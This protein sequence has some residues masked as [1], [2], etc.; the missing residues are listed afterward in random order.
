MES[1]GMA[2]F[3]AVAFITWGLWVNWEHGVTARWQVACTQGLVSFA[4]TFASAEIIRFITLQLRGSR[5]RIILWGGAI[6]YLLIYSAIAIVH[7][8]A[9]TPEIFATLLPGL[10]IGIP[11]CFSYAYRVTRS[12]PPTT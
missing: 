1:V 3:A 12:S 4:S 8:L 6:S 11:F 5:R 7:W 2:M 10:L 9:G